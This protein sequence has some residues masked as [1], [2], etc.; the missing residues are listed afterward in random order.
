MDSR[1]IYMPRERWRKRRFFRAK[2]FFFAILFLAAALLGGAVYALRYPGWQ[3]QTV[4][5]FG[6][7]ETMHADVEARVRE[8]L[9]ARFAFILPKSSYFLF[10]EGAVQK[11]LEK[12]FPWL[13]D[14]TVKKEFPS[15]VS[16]V[17]RERGLWAVFCD[18]NRTCG[19]MDK[20]GFIYEEAPV[21]TGA[22]IMTVETDEQE[23][24]IPSQAFDPAFV[25]KLDSFVLLL[26]EKTGEDV[27]TFLFSKEFPGEVRVRT[28][29][30]FL[31]YLDRDDD[32]GKVISILR[33]FLEKEIGDKRGR[34][35]YIDLR[36]GNKVFYK[37]QG[38]EK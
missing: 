16:V 25:Q 10:D 15:M 13:H 3:I 36:F 20:T 32:F 28:R 22:L 1:V 18:M 37:L 5:V 8:S 38:G 27:E 35:E 24:H 30:G 33:V 21:S 14:I 29:H 26:G 17:A 12:D 4:L 19:Y 11:T 6:F 9:D 7:D 31:L 34:L 23:V 2:F